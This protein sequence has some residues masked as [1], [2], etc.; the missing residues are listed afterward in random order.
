MSKRPVSLLLNDISEAIERILHEYFG[1][2]LEITWQILQGYSPLLQASI[3]R[4]RP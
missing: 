4:I 3:E 2:D 1:I